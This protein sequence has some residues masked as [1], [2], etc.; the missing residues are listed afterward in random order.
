MNCLEDLTDRL[1]LFPGFR[2]QIITI[3]ANNVTGEVIF[4]TH[5]DALRSDGDGFL[6]LLRH[7]DVGLL[8]KSRGSPFVDLRC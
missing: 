1:L 2:S 8:R 6:P 5:K 4:S 3:E 7:D